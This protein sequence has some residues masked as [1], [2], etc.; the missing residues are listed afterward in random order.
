MPIFTRSD[1]SRT[2]RLANRTTKLPVDL[3][4]FTFE[5]VV[6]ATRDAADRLACLTIGAGLTVAGPGH[7]LHRDDAD[8]RPDQRDRRRRP[9]LGALSH[10]RRPPHRAGVRQDDRPGRRVMA[11]ASTDLTID[12]AGPDPLTVF[13]ADGEMRLDVD[14]DAIVVEFVAVGAPGRD[15]VDG[16][17]GRDGVDGIGRQSN[18]RRLRRRRP[19]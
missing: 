17:D 8:G 7:R 6:K 9:G 1:Y 12:P 5:L 13:Q 11:A 4:G 10:R 16:V 2:L 15:G 14:V 19:G 3:T 18:G